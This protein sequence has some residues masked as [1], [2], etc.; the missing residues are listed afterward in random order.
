[1][2]RSPK[3]RKR[4]SGH[5]DR[6]LA[7]QG[8]LSA[9]KKSRQETDSD[10]GDSEHEQSDKENEV[11]L[12]DNMMGLKNSRSGAKKCRQSAADIA[13]KAMQKATSDRASMLALMETRNSLFKSFV[14]R[15]AP[16]KEINLAPGNSEFGLCI[17][18]A[19][20]QQV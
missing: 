5:Q 18:L 4:S 13:G 7:A 19:D 1:M 8:L 11:T 12:T 16:V 3:S 2:D 14:D 6:D 9:A 20:M 17:E 15:Q 10:T